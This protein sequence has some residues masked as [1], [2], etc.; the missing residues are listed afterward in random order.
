[1]TRSNPGTGPAGP[2]PEGGSFRDR[3]ARVFL[4]GERVLRALGPRALAAWE[5]YSRAAFFQKLSAEG[6]VVG[7]RRLTGPGCPAIGEGWVAILEHDRVPFVSYPYEWS[8]SMLKEAALLQLDVLLGALAEGFTLKDATPYNIQW[9]GTRPQFIDVASI[10]P[11]RE[12]EP[13]VGYR[14]FCQLFL[15]PLLLQ[16]ARGLPGPM[17][18][19]ARLDGIDPQTC[20]SMLRARDLL[21]RGVLTHV[22]LHAMAQGRFADAEVSSVDLMARAGFKRSMVERTVRGM[23]RVVAR[24]QARRRRSTWTEYRH[25]HSYQATDLQAKREFV[26]HFVAARR[27]GMV[28]DIGANTGD[29]SRIAA[30]HAPLVVA[31]EQEE[32]T[33]DRLFSELKVEGGDR[34]LPLVVDVTDPSPGMG[35]RCAE[36]R[37]LWDRG[38]PDLALCLALIHHVVIAGNVPLPEFVGWLAELGCDLVIE[39]VGKDDP[40]VRRLLLNKRDD[41]ADYDQTV[42]EACLGRAFAVES[43]M[44]LE[45]GTRTLYACRALGR[46]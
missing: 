2:H 37:T 41:Y 32:T 43:R 10:E 35:W 9:R 42:F 21:R 30:R 22:W 23:R 17:L 18:L 8:F 6:A 36:R 38:R 34:I 12:G 26:E 14:Q 29:F 24:L 1:M 45:S 27:P 33:V 19:R 46:Q 44:P 5:A 31:L 28:W 7:T 11:Y 15:Y 25:E 13:W 16:S 3:T 20:R 40:M 4:E 39:F